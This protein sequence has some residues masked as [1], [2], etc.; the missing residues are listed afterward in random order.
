MD[1]PNSQVKQFALK[2]LQCFDDLAKPEINNRVMRKIWE[3]VRNYTYK[4]ILRKPDKELK[5][6]LKLIHDT[7]GPM[8]TDVQ[9]SH[10]IREG[11]RLDSPKIPMVGELSKVRDL[12]NNE[13]QV[14]KELG[15]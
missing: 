13:E 11:E 6:K 5:E 1:Q 2:T 12:T 15:Y 8:F 4:I 10:Q 14:L 3:Y 7:L 9:I